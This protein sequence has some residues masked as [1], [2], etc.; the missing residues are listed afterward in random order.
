MH[1]K[2]ELE[3]PELPE[4]CTVVEAWNETN[5]VRKD[6]VTGALVGFC[7]GVPDR[8][9]QVFVEVQGTYWRDHIRPVPAW[10]PEKGEL[11]A[12]WDNGYGQVRL[13]AYVGDGRCLS[14]SHSDALLFDF[15]A[16]IP[17]GKRVFSEEELTPEWFL[18]NSEVMEA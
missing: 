3:L 14:E 18:A 17:D 5:G 11:V 1:K 13:R 16:R 9:Y 2:I 4:R 7:Y 10:A 8:R 15:I 12:C 6:E